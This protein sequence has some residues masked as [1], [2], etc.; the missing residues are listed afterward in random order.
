M[1]NA[2]IRI[3]CLAVACVAV[4]VA[5]AGR[6]NAAVLTFDPSP[7]ISTSNGK[8]VFSS[9]NF[10]TAGFYVESFTGAVVGDQNN[11]FVTNG[12]FHIGS[13]TNSVANVEVQH[14]AG[15]GSLQGIFIESSGG[16]PF[17]L[18][19]LDFRVRDTSQN[20]TGYS[21]SD[22][23]VL[24]STSFDP[25]QSV[26]SQFTA[27]SAGLVSTSFATLPV[28]GFDN[29]TRVF[30]TSSA[31]VSFDNITIGPAASEIPE[32]TTLIIWSLLA[33]L[34]L[35]FGWRRRQRAS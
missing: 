30:I 23:K 12:H 22:A 32:P 8:L 31:R 21:A 7:T 9:E 11:G 4:L 3:S 2:M 10:T 19:S 13:D 6:T 26:V 27:F 25:T 29:V 28:T 34:G 15:F 16:S 1:E 20:I 5:V 18:T 24:L 33:T 17:S 14:Y 35:S